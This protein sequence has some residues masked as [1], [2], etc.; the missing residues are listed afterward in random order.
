[1]N[2][3]FLYFEDCPSHD[4]ALERLQQV[5][6]E[7][8]IEATIEIISVETDDQAQQWQFTGSPTILIEGQDIVPPL[9]TS[10]GLSC[11]TYQWPDGRISP[12]P[13]PEMI[14]AALRAAV[15][16]GAER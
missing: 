8:N 16:A 3:Q 4:K 15:H 9:D 5:M 13:S 6:A 14:R 10:Y 11:R 7:A 1:M 12:L 2:I